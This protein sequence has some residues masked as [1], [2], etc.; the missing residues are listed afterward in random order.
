MRTTI[1]SNGISDMEV[2]MVDE[3]TEAQMK[4]AKLKLA[5]GALMSLDEVAA[6][7]GVAPH[8]VHGLPLA[9]IRLGRTFRFDPKDGTRLVAR[10]K[11][12]ALAKGGEPAMPPEITG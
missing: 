2:E 1:G 8:T 4:S 7:F 5:T 12:P 6:F 11:E 10:S 9:S 3:T